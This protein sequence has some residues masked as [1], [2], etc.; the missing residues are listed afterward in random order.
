M[1]WQETEDA[2]QLHHLV[3]GSSR[4]CLQVSGKDE[5]N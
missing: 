2:F 5:G 3:E 1:D 4:D